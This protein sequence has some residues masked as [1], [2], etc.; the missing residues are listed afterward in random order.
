[1]VKNIAKK[2]LRRIFAISSNMIEDIKFKNNQFSDSSEKIH[3]F[4]TD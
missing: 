3:L 1:M 2:I 4:K